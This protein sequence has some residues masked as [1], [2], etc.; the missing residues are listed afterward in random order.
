[1]DEVAVDAVEV[2]R[3]RRTQH[4]EAVRG[5]DHAHHATIDGIGSTLDQSLLA[6]PV[7]EAGGPT[8][9][10]GDGP[11][12]LRGGQASP[13][14][15]SKP[16]QDL[17]PSERESA[18]VPELL[19][20]NGHQLGVSLEEEAE[21]QDA[22]VFE[23]DA[24]DLCHDGTKASLL[25]QLLHEKISREVVPMHTTTRRILAPLLGSLFLLGAACSSDDQ[26]VAADEGKETNT[27]ALE[28]H[29][30]N[31]SHDDAEPNLST[32]DGAAASTS[33]DSADDVTSGESDDAM[34]MATPSEDG[35]NQG[36]DGD[37]DLI[38]PVEMNDF[39]YRVAVTTI[40]VGSTVLFDFVNV[41]IVEHEAMLGT[42]H[43]QEE[44][45]AEADHRDHGDAGHHGTV[46]AIT[47]DP[48]RSG[49][50]V[51]EF[52]EAGEILIGCHL[53]GHWAAGMVTTLDVA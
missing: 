47:L 22:L 37:V 50:L 18:A 33:K 49:T 17:E 41:G 11:G 9:R 31:E 43:Q 21:G 14:T 7:D 46:P 42:M 10:Q 38:I 45:A 23:G 52:D 6:Q 36:T 44:F 26:V 2:D 8:T 12:Q 32:D 40:P 30:S 24:R 20:E 53:P 3:D 27:E 1:L 19:V 28:D 39:G 35:A 51:V 16:D 15:P 4:V 25:A 29:G 5:Q 48:G 34:T 13:G